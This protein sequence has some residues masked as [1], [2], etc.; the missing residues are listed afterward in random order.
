MN[1]YLI[2]KG[3]YERGKITEERLHNAVLQGLITEE[4][5]LEIIGQTE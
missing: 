4:E 2:L 5:M 1:W 3:L